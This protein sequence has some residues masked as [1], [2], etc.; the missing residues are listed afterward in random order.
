MQITFFSEN[1]CTILVLEQHEAFQIDP[2]KLHNNYSN[3]NSVDTKTI[4]TGL[5]QLATGR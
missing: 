4:V 1:L 2:P 3:S 5:I